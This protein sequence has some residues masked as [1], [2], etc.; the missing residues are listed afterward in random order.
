ME[1][2]FSGKGEYKKIMA[3]PIEATEFQAG[4]IGS[5]LIIGLT[6]VAEAPIEK[7]FNE[8]LGPDAIGNKV[9][10]RMVNEGIAKLHPISHSIRGEAKFLTEKS[11]P[12]Y[13]DEINAWRVIIN[14]KELVVEVREV[15]ADLDLSGNDEL[16]ISG[17]VSAKKLPPIEQRFGPKDIED[18][19]ELERR[20]E[21]EGEVTLAVIDHHSKGHERAA[22]LIA[23]IEK[24][25]KDMGGI[26]VAPGREIVETSFTQ[27][28]VDILFPLA[29]H[30]LVTKIS[31]HDTAES[32]GEVHMT[33]FKA[34]GRE[35]SQA[36]AA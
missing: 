4:L 24:I 16:F 27:E 17:A 7:S 22:E 30:I 10:I 33:I 13:I 11:P 20:V 12:L 8:V 15:S 34:R 32:A 2:D 6:A 9:D 29:P 25:L 26:T 28:Q 18:L 36:K 3:H 1:F 35:V 19:R 21:L 31:S 5:A 14:G 23:H